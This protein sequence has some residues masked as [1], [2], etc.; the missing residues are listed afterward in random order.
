M[1]G[2]IP[3]SRTHNR[4]A[5]HAPSFLFCGSDTGVERESWAPVSRRGWTSVA[6]RND[7]RRRGVSCLAD[8]CIAHEIQK[9]PLRAVFVYSCGPEQCESSRTNRE[10]GPA[11]KT[12]RRKSFELWATRTL[13]YRNR[14][15][16]LG[17]RQQTGMDKRRRE[18][19]Y[20]SDSY[21]ADCSYVDIL[22]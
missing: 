9:Q 4:K 1:T 2:S 17:P 20:L 21:I 11:T 6:R 13:R 15:G 19:S 18:V 12:F 10:A 16:V 3:V 5:G 22:T 7:E 8:S 14:K